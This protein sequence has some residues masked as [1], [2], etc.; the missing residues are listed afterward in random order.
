MILGTNIT[1]HVF[2]FSKAIVVFYKYYMSNKLCKCSEIG[3]INMY[4]HYLTIV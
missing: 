1:V 3:V 4:S 2:V